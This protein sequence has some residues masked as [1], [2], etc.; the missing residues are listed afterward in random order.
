MSLF[1]N[2]K[3]RSK[4]LI[5]NTTAVVFLLLIGTVSY[6]YVNDMAANSKTM[7]EESLIKVKSINQV[8]TNFNSIM[9]DM[10][11]LMLNTD[12][13]TNA[14]LKQHFEDTFAANSK[15]IKGY[16]EFH[17]STEEQAVYDNITAGRKDLRALEDK[18]ATLAMQNKNEEAYRVY[19]S[20]LEPTKIKIEGFY[21]QLSQ[22]AEDAAKQSNIENNQASQVSKIVS[23]VSVAAAILLL[24]LLSA[25]ITRS[26]TRPTRELQELM[27]LAAEG[28]FSSKGT[29]VSKDETGMLTASYNAMVGSLST[30]VK[31]ISENAVTLAASSEELQASSEQSAQATEHISTQIQE[32][33][34]GSES[35]AR[36]SVEMNRTMQEMNVGIQRIAESATEL[37][38]ESQQSEA[39]V[40]KGHAKLEEAIRE[41]EQ[42]H[43]SIGALSEVVT[44]LNEKS[45]SIGQITDTI[46]AIAD[47]TS[48]LSLNAAIEAARA[49]EEGRGFAVV[50]AEVK[51][52][53]EQTQESSSN[54]SSLIGQI[55]SETQVAFR[56]MEV[57][58]SQ[59]ENGRTVMS[60]VSRVFDGIMESA[61]NLSVQLHEVSAVTEEMSAS[62]EQVLAT[63]ESS[64]AIASSS[65]DMTQSVAAAT[66][67]QL[68]SVQEVTGSA[69]YLSK[70]AQDLQTSI[71]RFKI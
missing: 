66:E 18:V 3:L 33:S 56:S 1:R 70:L 10:L 63:V 67:E 7:Y 25:L 15:I 53:A 61:R 42:I 8:M 49:G 51:K 69:S 47:Q 9:N 13:N 5:L 62:S 27:K 17:L 14:E 57:S 46:K 68:A 31:Q 24:A 35:Q 43:F 30:L 26:I 50:A 6:V 55:Q 71:E 19:L 37:A 23:I 41:M 40:K 34:E 38:V 28:D 20:E 36:G 11:Q 59:A 12:A 54:V 65:K 39:S 4:L 44:S 52:L 22:L 48:L 58:R 2:F 60:D 64:A 45:A 21:M 16:G 32:I 29:N